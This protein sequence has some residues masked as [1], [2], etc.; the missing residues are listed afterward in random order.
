ML[1]THRP[2][3]QVFGPSLTCDCVCELAGGPV[4]ALWTAGL[5]HSLGK[6]ERPAP[7]ARHKNDDPALFFDQEG[8]ASGPH[9][10]SNSPCR[11]DR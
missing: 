5:L 6:D 11:V 2:N 8:V 3:C 7:T 10:L 9:L 4:M 1:Q